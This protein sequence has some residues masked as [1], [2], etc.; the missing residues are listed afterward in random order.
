MLTSSGQQSAALRLRPLA[1]TV[2]GLLALAAVLLFVPG[3]F[4]GEAQLL[5]EPTAFIDPALL[6]AL[7]TQAEVE[8]FI[9]LKELDLPITEWTTEMRRQNTAER[10]ARVLSVLTDSDFTLIHQF[11]IAPALS[12]RISKSG[13]Q[14]LA[15]HPDVVDIALDVKV[16]GDAVEPTFLGDGDSGDR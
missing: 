6:E 2:L 3:R 9:S 13:V 11:E 15:S 8:V 1:L 14:K 16:F 5:Q 7:E 12:G 4:A 10:Q